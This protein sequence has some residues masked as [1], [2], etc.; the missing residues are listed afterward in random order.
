MAKHNKLFKVKKTKKSMMRC[1]VGVYK[2]LSSVADSLF[3][4]VPQELYDGLAPIYDLKARKELFVSKRGVDDILGL[5]EKLRSRKGVFLFYC[6]NQLGDEDFKL[7]KEN[8]EIFYMTSFL[9]TKSAEPFVRTRWSEEE[10]WGVYLPDIVFGRSSGNMRANWIASYLDNDDK[11][12]TFSG[13]I[14]PKEYKYSKDLKK[15]VESI[16]EGDPIVRNGITLRMLKEVK[17]PESFLEKALRV[18]DGR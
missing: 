6:F 16:L 8:S 17:N 4:A 1:P 9:R 15:E 11:M 7:L 13:I 18:E 5:S 10:I 2:E 3:E 12:S 14:I